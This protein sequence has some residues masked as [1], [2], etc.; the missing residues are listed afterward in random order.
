M[1]EM[2]KF[3][4]CLCLFCTRLFA[5]IIRIIFVLYQII[6]NIENKLQSVR[7]KNEFGA[8]VQSERLGR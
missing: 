5:K 7:M 3:S 8:C 1:T 6:N 4:S 2:S